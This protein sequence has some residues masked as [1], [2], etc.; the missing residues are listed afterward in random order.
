MKK[1]ILIIVIVLAGIFV[2]IQLIPYGHNHNNPAVT[3]PYAWKDPQAEAIARKAC[4]DCHSNET[5]WPWYSNIAPISWMVQSHVDEG[6]QRLNFSESRGE[7]DEIPGEVMEGG[8]PPSS[9]TPMHPDAR[10]TD[11]E[12][13]ILSNEFGGASEGGE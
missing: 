11:Q 4:F 10:L 1:I 7:L 6:R 2:L 13:Q 5:V 9:Y 8:M 12:K 3:N